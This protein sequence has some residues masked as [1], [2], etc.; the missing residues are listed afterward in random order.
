MTGPE[1]G[2]HRGD[3]I[4]EHC[5]AVRALG[6]GRAYEVYEAFDEQMLVPV[7][8]KIVR[9]HLVSDVGTLRGLAREVDLL[10]RL[11]H[12]V[13]V[14]GFHAALGTD[15]PYVALEF[16]P[17]PRLSTLVR[18]NG[19]LP[20]DQL[21]PL[22]VDIC[23]ALHYLHRCAVVHLDVKPSNIIM[24]STPRLIDLSIARSAPEASA[25]DHVVGTDRYMS[26]EQCEATG[27][28]PAADIWGLGVSLYEAA[29]GHRPFE[30]TEGERH[31]Q[32]HDAPLPPPESSLF[33]EIVMACLQRDPGGR[34][35]AREVMAALSAL[36]ESLPS[37][38]IG[39]FRPRPR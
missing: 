18:T 23:T 30:D 8:V 22:G 1:W 25:L 24:D 7:V 39:F 21:L 31:P 35:S 29:Y 32:R 19:P 28:G 12:P 20:A 34:P 27:A 6:G 5:S 33:S 37:P 14:R 26:P 13:L 2:F 11:N 38:R 10:G 9:P 4:V 36:T 3:R 15:R 16:L 17:G